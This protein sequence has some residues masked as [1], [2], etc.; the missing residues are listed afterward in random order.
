[1]GRPQDAESLALLGRSAMA[2]KKSSKSEDD[3]ELEAMFEEPPFAATNLS[4]AQQAFLLRTCRFLVNVHTPGYADRARRE[5]Y[6]K[7][8]HALGWK[9]CPS[10]TLTRCAQ[11][12]RSCIGAPLLE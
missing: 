7:D 10:G 4:T 1:M 11:D 12:A 9:L 6:T 3:V 5:G 8:D 2:R